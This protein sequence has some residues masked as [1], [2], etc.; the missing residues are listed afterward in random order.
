M[1]S[2]IKVN[3]I[4]R[5]EC[6]I[7]LKDVETAIPGDEESIRHP[8]HGYG[9]HIIQT[10]AVDAVCDTE[11]EFRE[12]LGKRIRKA[13]TAR[14]YRGFRVQPYYTRIVVDASIAPWLPPAGENGEQ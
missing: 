6:W 8:G 9:A 4:P 13:R 2:V 1:K 11:A 12:E 10:V 3:D 5:N 14:I 7:I